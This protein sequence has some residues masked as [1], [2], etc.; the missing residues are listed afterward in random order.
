MSIKVNQ[1]SLKNL[2]DRREKDALI[3]AMLTDDERAEV[4]RF[5]DSIKGFT[6]QEIMKFTEKQPDRRHPFFK[7]R[8]KYG[9]EG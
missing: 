5:N 9:G 2:D 4:D 6:M 3:Y 7:Y 8:K 1:T